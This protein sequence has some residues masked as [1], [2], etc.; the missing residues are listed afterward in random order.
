MCEP[1]S[2]GVHAV[3][4]GGVSAGT[5]V[6]VFGAGPIG[7]PPL[8]TPLRGIRPLRMPFIHCCAVSQGYSR[9]F[10]MVC[11]AAVFTLRSHSFKNALRKQHL[12][13]YAS[14]KPFETLVH[15]NP[16]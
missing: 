5:D 12:Q 2:V 3:R 9:R 6:A 14:S 8:M 16:V 11:I 7:S 15:L 13:Q 1:L 10:A 4:R